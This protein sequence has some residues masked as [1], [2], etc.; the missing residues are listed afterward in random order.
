MSP[1]LCAS[2]IRCLVDRQEERIAGLKE[3]ETRAAYMKQLCRI[4]AEAGPED[5]VPVL[6]ER[7]NV[8][9]RQLF[10]ELTDFTEI[11]K[12]FNRLMLSAEKELEVKI[13]ASADPVKTA[14]LYARAANYIDFGAYSH[15]SRDTLSTL[16][17][18]A[19]ADEL[20]EEVYELLCR[21]LETAKELV[22]VTDNCGEVVADKLVIRILKER[23]RD[24]H[25]TVL[26][27]GAQALNDATLEDARQTGLSEEA[28]VMAN[29]SGVTGTP[30]AC[31][32]PQAKELLEK[33]DV[34]I[35]KGQGNYET[36]NGCGLNVY[37]S[38][39]CKC[40]WFQKRFGLSQNKG[41][42]IRE[43]D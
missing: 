23:W 10:G 7:V 20:E 38:F 1:K 21:D 28:D 16:L 30:L 33:A 6:V 24:L 12:E 32:S 14:M 18:K 13:R 39:L 40:D 41:V 4:I 25:V 34:I 11:K 15:V 19:A 42:L 17:E 35:A 27:R 5:T 9:Y 29:G 26:V 3:E 36:M 22:Y 43:K 31:I 8:I 2:C 37:Y